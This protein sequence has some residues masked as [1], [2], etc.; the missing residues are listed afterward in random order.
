MNQSSIERE[1]FILRS[2]SMSG[3]GVWVLVLRFFF[4]CIMNG[5]F[6]FSDLDSRNV[7]SYCPHPFW[8]IAIFSLA[9]SF[10]F[11]RP[12]L[13]YI[14]SYLYI[15]CLRTACSFLHWQSFGQYFSLLDSFFWAICPAKQNV[16]QIQC[17]LEN[18]IPRTMHIIY[19]YIYLYIYT[20]I[21][22]C[23]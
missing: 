14:Y 5:M 16:D 17:I 11:N 7:L 4:L 13:S 22:I 10:H 20:Y 23:I 19:I 3:C 6:S 12:L 18:Y 21:Y 15:R 9:P 2:V 1:Y 8:N